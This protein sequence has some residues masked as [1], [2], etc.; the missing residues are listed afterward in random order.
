M[1]HL[2]KLTLFNSHDMRTMSS[3]P[4]ID[5]YNA[6]EECRLQQL[7]AIG[8]IPGAL[9][10]MVIQPIPSSCMEACDANGGNPLGLEAK[11]HQCTSSLGSTLG[12]QLPC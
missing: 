6:A 2:W 7:K 1:I 12:K 5:V 9:I 3:L 8:H 4:D 10:T 11:G